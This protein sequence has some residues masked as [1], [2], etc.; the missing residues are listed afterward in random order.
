M[1]S[2]YF[3][4]AQ[5]PINIEDMVKADGPVK[6]LNHNQV[7]QAIGYPEK[8]KAAKANGKVVL[9]VDFD[10][11]GNYVSH[12]V[13]E[14]AHPLLLEAVEAQ[15]KNIKATPAKLNGKPIRY[16]YNVPFKFNLVGAA[17][18]DVIETLN[19]EE[20][21]AKIGYPEK[22][23]KKGITGAVV[24]AVMADEKGNVTNFKTLSS[25]DKSLTEAVEKNISLLKFKPA[26]KDGVPATFKTTVKIE[27]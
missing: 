24:I 9:R 18:E 14:S 26:M 25:P 20:V 16:S 19:F 4:F 10:E 5:P 27:F 1:L 6:L 23:K 11:K 13:K 17:S 22:A 15:I 7:M 21:R 12:T 8:A 3:S 2:F